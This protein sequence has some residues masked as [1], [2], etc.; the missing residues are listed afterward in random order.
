MKANKTVPKLP[1]SRNPMKTQSIIFDRNVYSLD[2]AKAWLKKHGF[3][4]LL[5]YL[6][7]KG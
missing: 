3:K 1:K 2:E 7:K 4:N 5:Q 6:S